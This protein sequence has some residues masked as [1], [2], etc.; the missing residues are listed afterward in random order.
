MA[1][2]PAGLGGAADY[3]SNPDLYG[4]PPQAP[5]KPIP[6]PPVY[7]YSGSS[8]PNRPEPYKPPPTPQT[9]ISTRMGSI[10]NYGN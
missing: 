2:I 6:K 10:G 8:T 7:S 4:A 5:V 3:F 9:S 1:P